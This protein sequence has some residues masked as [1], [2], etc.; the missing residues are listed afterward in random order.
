MMETNGITY[1]LHADQLGSIIAITRKDGTL[2]EQYA[3]S[4]FG[5]VR[6][7]NGS[8]VQIQES[9]VG[10]IFGFTGREFDSES[11]LYYYRA[12]YYDPK[13][14]RFISEDPIGFYGEDFNIFR[15]VGNNPLR[16][17]DPSGKGPVSYVA[18]I[19]ADA[20][21]NAANALAIST[22]HLNNA[23]ILQDQIDSY[24]HQRN[25]IGGGD[26]KSCSLKDRAEKK[27]INEKISL[28]RREQSYQQAQ[29]LKALLNGIG[30]TT[31]GLAACAPLLVIP[32]LP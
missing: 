13:L 7:F 10:N 28:A 3:Y 22:G 25:N 14:G 27:R 16:F 24:V 18:C 12:R 11:H 2:I 30:P 21:R 19:T 8:G 15:Y 5:E 29:S 31:E 6:I 23:Q 26:G 20:A 17:K 4:A 1:Y 9:Q 32:G